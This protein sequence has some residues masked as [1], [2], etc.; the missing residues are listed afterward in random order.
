[1]AAQRGCLWWA[2]HHRN[3]HRCADT[4]E[5]VHSPSQQGFLWSHVLWLMTPRNFPTHTKRVQDWSRYP[6][7]R[8][9][10]RF[11]MLV[12]VLTVALLYGLGELIGIARPVSG[13][14]GGQMV[15]WAFVI[16]TVVLYHVT[17]TINS[18]DHMI[19]S[20]RYETPDT[21]RNNFV[22]AL[23]TFGEGWHNNHHRYA[24][25]ARQGFRWWEVDATYYVLVAL[26]WLGLVR[27]L[28]PVPA[29]VLEEDSNRS[30]P[31]ESQQS[32]HRGDED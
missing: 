24:T 9:L 27:D 19:G 3:H 25:S 18:L 7:L 20:R 29:K 31:Q 21:S 30:T 12:P 32:L 8:F 10:N 6:E 14:T 15:I 13:I 17:F 23:L 16:P 22:L 26:S 11:S 4:P 28:R 2:S 1:M 5:D